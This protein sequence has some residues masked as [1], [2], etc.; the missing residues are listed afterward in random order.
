MSVCVRM[1]VCVQLISKK[2]VK[3]KKTM[4]TVSLFQ[5][6]GIHKTVKKINICS[7]PLIHMYYKSHIIHGVY[8]Y[9]KPLT[10]DQLGMGSIH[11]F[12]QAHAHTLTSLPATYSPPPP[13]RQTHTQKCHL[14]ST[15]MSLIVLKGNHFLLYLSDSDQLLLALQLILEGKFVSLLFRTPLLKN[16]QAYYTWTNIQTHVCILIHCRQHC[17]DRHMATVI[18]YW[19]FQHAFLFCAQIV[20]SLACNLGHLD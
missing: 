18:F 11:T 17:D 10:L 8:I 16:R 4:L 1:W 5:R 3:V 14:L 2:K 6:T 19:L 20:S 7:T 12:T 15:K 13:D 9:I